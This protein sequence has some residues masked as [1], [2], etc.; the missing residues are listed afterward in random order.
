[1]PGR[2]LKAWGEEGEGCWKA[3]KLER[4]YREREKYKD[5]ERERGRGRVLERII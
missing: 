2:G 3:E 5:R 4:G 1:M